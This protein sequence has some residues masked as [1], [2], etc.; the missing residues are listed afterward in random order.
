MIQCTLPVLLP[1]YVLICLSSFTC[2]ESQV[3][4]LVSR[5]F[6]LEPKGKWMKLLHSFVLRTKTNHFCHFFGS[7]T[8]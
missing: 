6:K 3:K 1:M 7:S 2:F 5:I 4:I 8:L